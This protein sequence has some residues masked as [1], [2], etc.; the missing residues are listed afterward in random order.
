MHIAHACMHVHILQ[1]RK[2]NFKFDM[3]SKK[4]KKKQQKEDDGDDVGSGDG[5]NSRTRNEE[6]VEMC[7]KIVYKLI[8]YMCSMWCTYMWLRLRIR[9]QTVY[10]YD[11]H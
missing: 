6:Y 7:A 5:K 9:A 8:G 10:S 1:K 4:K 11:S 2:H 3:A